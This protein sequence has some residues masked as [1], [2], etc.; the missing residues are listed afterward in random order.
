MEDRTL[1][2]RKLRWIGAALPAAAIP[3]PIPLVPFTPVTPEYLGRQR[4]ELRQGVVPRARRTVAA[5][6]QA[7]LAEVSLKGVERIAAG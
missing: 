5:R 7:T 6:Q 3:F 2:T 1:C 4:L